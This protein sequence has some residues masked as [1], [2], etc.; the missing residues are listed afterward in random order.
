MPSHNSP[1]KSKGS[2][3]RRKS[4]HSS[5]KSDGKSTF[6]N[7]YQDIHNT[8]KQV[9]DFGTELN[10]LNKRT[11]DLINKRIRKE[12]RDIAAKTPSIY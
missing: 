12:L 5:K 7:P 11:D 8:M 9:D 6:N 10:N 1:H 3:S 4:K 2:S